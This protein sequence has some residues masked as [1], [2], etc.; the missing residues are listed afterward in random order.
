VTL[1][2]AI[3][4]ASK[5]VRE[6]NLREAV[7]AQVRDPRPDSLTVRLHGYEQATEALAT[8][9]F[10]FVGLSSGDLVLAIPISSGQWVVV[11]R[12]TGAD[13]EI[14]IAADQLEIPA[15]M[16]GPGFVDDGEYNPVV[17]RHRS[18]LTV[19]ADGVSEHTYVYPRPYEGPPFVTPVMEATSHSARLAV[20][21]KSVARDQVV[22]EVENNYGSDVSGRYHLLLIGE[23]T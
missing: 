20:G 19:F 7:L 22:L 2:R 14:S 1:A 11:A 17:Q 6:A 3:V 4:E 18:S 21:L 12:L 13:P 16:A 23:P 8:D 10:D 5:R 9:Y 15:L